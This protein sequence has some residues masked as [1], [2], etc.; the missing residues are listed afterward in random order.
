MPFLNNDSSD[1]SDSVSEQMQNYQNVPEMVQI[2]PNRLK[3][4]LAIEIEQEKLK[5][6]C[7][8]NV[9]F[10]NLLKTNKNQLSK[11]DE[12]GSKLDVKDKIISSQISAIQNQSNLLNG[13]AKNLREMTLL[14]EKA[15]E[16]HEEDQKTIRSIEKTNRGLSEKIGY[17]DRLTEYVEKLKFKNEELVTFNNRLKADNLEFRDDKKQLKFMMDHQSGVLDT[18]ER[19]LKSA[20]DKYRLFF[21]QCFGNF[22]KMIWNE[23]K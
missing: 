6:A 17:S 11:I 4:C 10:E 23:L 13:S 16:K 22:K 15:K 3:T 9:T 18:V 2:E 5:S 12:Q 19:D 1:D 8:E 21:K 7:G 14:L 20:L